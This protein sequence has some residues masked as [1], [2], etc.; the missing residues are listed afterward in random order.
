MGLTSNMKF[1]MFYKYLTNKLMV[2]LHTIFSSV[3]FD[4]DLSIISLVWNFPFVVSYSA[5]KIAHLGRFWILSFQGCLACSL[6]TG[7]NEGKNRNN[8]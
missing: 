4:F 2:A 1:V 5:Q 7:W 6:F 8:I 3:N